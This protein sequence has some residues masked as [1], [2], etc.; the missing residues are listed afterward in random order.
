MKSL[1]LATVIQT[2]LLEYL[3]RRLV[4]T[5]L[6]GAVFDVEPRNRR[7]NLGLS[8]ISYVLC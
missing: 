1:T 5:N 6:S 2:Q 8:L 3:T 7:L 4:H